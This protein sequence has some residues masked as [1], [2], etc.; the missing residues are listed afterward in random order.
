MRKITHSH[1]RLCRWRRASLISLLKHS[2][3]FLFCKHFPLP[4]PLSVSAVQ[5]K[6]SWFYKTFND[7]KFKPFL[8]L[9]NVTVDLCQYLDHGNSML[10]DMF[11]DQIKKT[12]NLF[13]SCPFKVC[14]I[15]IGTCHVASACAREM[16]VLLV[17]ENHFQGHCYV[18]DFSPSTKRWPSIIPSGEYYMWFLF[19]TKKSNADRILLHVKFYAE[20]K[21]IR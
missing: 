5:V 6:M 10:V 2:R 1:F 18:K 8:G 19:Y 16:N 13:H 9:S 7:L 3:Y 17:N 12:S 14:F 11:I 20:V 21:T 15:V 4:V